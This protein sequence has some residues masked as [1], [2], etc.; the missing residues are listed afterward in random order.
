MK[1]LSIVITTYN[2]SNLVKICLEKLL[3]MSSLYEIIV[4][5]DA[6]IDDTE[7]VIK[8]FQN[9]K[10]KYFKNEQNLG[11]QRSYFNGLKKAKGNYVTFLADDDEYIDKDFF[12]NI[13]I[14]NEDI[15]S[16]K[17]ETVLNGKVI[18][19]DFKC[20]KEIINTDEALNI[21]EQFMFGGNTIFKKDILL[22]VINY[23]FEHDFSFI[24]FCLIYA[25]K[26]RFINKVVFYW[27]SDLKGNTFSSK[28]LK[29]PYD[30]LL[31]SIKFLDEIIPILKQMNLFEKYKWFIDKRIFNIFE[32]VEFNYY[33]AD[34]DIYFKK[35]LRKIKKEVYI[36][37]YGQTGV[38]L[39]EFLENNNIKVLGFIDDYKV[40]CLNIN[41]ID[42]SKD[43]IIATFKRTLNH[44]MY[45]NLVN[46]NIK[47]IIE[48][49]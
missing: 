14:Y 38:L 11:I 35:L 17:Y 3:K 1:T 27:Y 36:Y 26:I 37:G 30:H 31:W 21:F 4:V 44:K 32:E 9:K 25:K 6:S 40:N 10:I 5:D 15:I 45:K 19:N 24:F 47:N 42:E 29:S 28:F 46:G 8:N 39:K 23:N 12:E 16:A 41:D 43:V 33:L 18:R 2:R 7:K 13:H 34:K 48:L 49:I 20:K 22:K